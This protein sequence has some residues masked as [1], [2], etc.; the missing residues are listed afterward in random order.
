MVK[1]LFDFL[2][3]LYAAAPLL[4]ALGVLAALA[5]W[6]S[7]SIKRYA[8][9]YYLVFSLPFLLVAVPFT[10]RLFG[11]E[12]F[13]FAGIPLLGGIL[14]DYIHAGTLAF[15]LL[16]LI[17]Y[18]GALDGKRRYVKRLMSIRKELSIMSGFPVLTHSLIRVANNLPGAVQF[19]VDREGY[20]EKTP[21]GSVP[22]M[23]VTSFSFVLG[24]LMLALFVPLWATSFDGVRRRMGGRRW[25]RFQRW[26]YVLYGMLFIH[27]L[28]IQVGGMLNP[29]EGRGTPVAAK[30]VRVSPEVQGARP[31]GIGFLDIK[32]SPG[33]RRTVHVVSLFLVFGSYVYLKVRKHSLTPA[34]GQSRKP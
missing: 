10:A 31:R 20:L 28:G 6:L 16:I 18:M 12:V 29:R 3:F 13:N 33:T 23:E 26:S 21:V 11:V 32:V 15:P 2:Q 34:A 19:L 4:T 24:V 22:G 30:E 9:I 25:K 27:S 1:L 5:V 8:K 7:G 14:R 17:M